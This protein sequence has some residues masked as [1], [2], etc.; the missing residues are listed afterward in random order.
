MA[1]PAPGGCSLA[2][3]QSPS[4]HRRPWGRHGQTPSL[5][6]VLGTVSRDDRE[7]DAGA[8]TGIPGLLLP[9]VYQ[10]QALVKNNNYPFF[11]VLPLLLRMRCSESAS[12]AAWLM[13]LPFLDSGAWVRDVPMPWHDPRGP[14]TS[15]A[16]ETRCFPVQEHLSFSSCWAANF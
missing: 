2:G 1:S 9:L 14:T 15:S 6:Q 13:Y 12:H 7:G 16:L 10:L 8:A 3:W 5:Q 4:R 11:F